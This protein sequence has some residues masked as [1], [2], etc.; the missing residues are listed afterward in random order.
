MLSGLTIRIIQ[1]QEKIPEISKISIHSFQADLTG[2]ARYIK[3][4]AENLLKAPSW[5]IRA[6]QP[7][8]IYTDEIVVM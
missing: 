7:M 2:S 6:G 8:S 4:H 3:V 1:T 5:H